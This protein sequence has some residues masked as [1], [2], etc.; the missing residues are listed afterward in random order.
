MFRLIQV[1]TVGMA[2]CGVASAAEKCAVIH[3]A[4]D[5]TLK[6]R[7]LPSLSVEGLAQDEPFR[8][9]DDAPPNVKA[10]MCGRDALVLGANDYKV[11]RANLTISVV[12][13]ERVA[14]LEAVNGQLRFRVSSGK[15]TPQESE[16]TQRAL[17]VE[18]V[19][20]NAP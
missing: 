20:F 17:D 16:R 7:A 1:L 13:D 3:E 10:L 15:M 2:L 9:P 5:G 11:L 8:L 14:V 12:A 4:P 18:Q 6:T 19:L